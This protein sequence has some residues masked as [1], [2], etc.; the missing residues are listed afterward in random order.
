MMKILL[1][2]G[3][4]VRCQ[5]NCWMY[6]IKIRCRQVHNACIKV[7]EWQ[8][9]RIKIKCSTLSW[10]PYFTSSIMSLHDNTFPLLSRWNHSHASMPPKLF[11]WLSAI[12]QYPQ[13]VSCSLALS[14]RHYGNFEIYRSQSCAA[15][16]NL[17]DFISPTVNSTLCSRWF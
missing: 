15:L 5:L 3:C 17:S 2:T 13:C 6:Y 12:L 10:C 9:V 1:Y 14:H 8:S 4:W 11:R 16:T 7:H